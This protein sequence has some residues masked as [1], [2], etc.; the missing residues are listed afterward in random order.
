DRRAERLHDPGPDL[1]P[2][3]DLRVVE[4][5]LGDRDDHRELLG[6]EGDVL[7]VDRAGLLHPVVTRH[8]VGAGQHVQDRLALA[9]GRHADLSSALQDERAG[10]HLLQDLV[11]HGGRDERVVALVPLDDVVVSHGAYLRF[12][13]A[14]APA[15]WRSGSGDCELEWVPHQ[16]RR[17]SRNSRNM[18]LGSAGR[19]FAGRAP[20][21]RDSTG[22]GGGGGSSNSSSGSHRGAAAA[23]FSAS[24]LALA[25]ISSSVPSPSSSIRSC[26][27]LCSAAAI[28]R[29]FITRAL[30]SSCSY[31]LARSSA[32]SSSVLSRSSYSCRRAR[33]SLSSRS[34]SRRA[35]RSSLRARL[36]LSPSSSSASPFAGSVFASLP[37]PSGV[38]GLVSPPWPPVSSATAS[39]RSRSASAVSSPVAGEASRSAA[40]GA[41]VSDGWD[42]A[43][44]LIRG[45]P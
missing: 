41:G 42:I 4:V 3:R 8:P 37:S 6:H 33:S 34:A 36:P 1:V 23:S 39:A 32:F 14:A 25:S 38:S 16:R 10:R 40:S 29:A 24:S 21:V 43:S 26:G 13:H 35:F 7:P 18:S 15:P 19:S 31:C 2:D 12:R 11:R 5:R 45:V 22:R 30:A 44:S 27:K 9:L 20:G 28:S 17:A